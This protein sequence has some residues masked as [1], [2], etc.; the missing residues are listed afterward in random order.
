MAGK[1]KTI[2]R[3][4]RSGPSPGVRK[5]QS[6]LQSSKRGAAALRK[7]VKESTSGQAAL[8]QG[9]SSAGG[10]GLAGVA[11]SALGGGFISK[12]ARGGVGSALIIAGG[13]VVPGKLGSIIASVGCGM[14]DTVAYEGGQYAGDMIFA[15]GDVDADAV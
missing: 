7:R 4:R 3:V 12:A 11:D 1:K 14:V 2:T 10:A 13:F 15:G 5:L 6:A 8:I 9:A